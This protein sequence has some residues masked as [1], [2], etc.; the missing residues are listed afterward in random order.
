[1]KRDFGV[2]SG[3]AT[4]GDSEETLLFTTD[5]DTADVAEAEVVEVAEADVAEAK[6]E[7]AEVAEADV[8]EDVETYPGAIGDH[9]CGPIVNPCVVAT[10]EP[11]F[12]QASI[13]KECALAIGDGAKALAFRTHG[14]FP[15]SIIK[16][17]ATRHSFSE[18]RKGHMANEFNFVIEDGNT[19]YV[20]PIVAIQ[21]RIKRLLP[22]CPPPPSS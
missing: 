7:V 19:Y 14:Y 16:V 18:F 3:T 15:I 17:A 2:F 4:K 22:H 6:A 5:T 20:C 8:A 12:D 9:V 10:E 1:M 13:K 21:G 11:C